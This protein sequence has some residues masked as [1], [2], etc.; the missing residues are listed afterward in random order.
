MTAGPLPRRAVP[1]CRR[2]VQRA[3]PTVGQEASQT[4]P[5]RSQRWTSGRPVGGRSRGY[6]REYRATKSCA[7]AQRLVTPGTNSAAQRQRLGTDPVVKEHRTVTTRD[8]PWCES[9]QAC[10]AAACQAG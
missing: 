10:N 2:S 9:L 7:T 1:Q 6:Y 3:N 5:L 8:Y 4:V